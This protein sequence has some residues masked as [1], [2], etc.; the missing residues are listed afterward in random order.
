MKKLPVFLIIILLL[1]LPAGCKEEPARAPATG[2]DAGNVENRS[3]QENSP[4]VDSLKPVEQKTEKP[5]AAPAPVATT[6]PAG[7][8]YSW[9][10]RPNSEHQTP[11]VSDDIQSLLASYNAFYVLPN[12]ANKIYLTFDEG[13]EN[14]YTGQIL[15]ILKANNVQVAFFI[16][17][18]YLKTQPELVQR[19]KNEGHLVCN[20]TM[21]HPDLSTVSQEKFEQEISSLATDYQRL[22][23]QEID[24]YLRP[25]MGNYS[26]LSLGY[27]RDMGYQTVF[28]SMAFKDWD[29]SQQPGAQYS[30]Q[31]VINNI[32]PGAVILLHA[33]S[34]SNTEALDGIIKDLTAQGYT[35]ALFD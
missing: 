31:H 17:G 3:P 19:M 16:T 25:P 15:D 32:H 6:K 1:V 30:H 28:W 4:S 11:A 8:S 5:A 35:F 21:N 18:H 27:A 2:S 20:H 12:N 34:Q 14:G 13:Y 10:F 33:V 29:I 23:G 24:K 26:P 22:T 9:Y 7:E